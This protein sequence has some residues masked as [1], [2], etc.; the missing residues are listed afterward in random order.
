MLDEAAELELEQVNGCR[1]I[2]ALRILLDKSIRQRNR[3]RYLNRRQRG[4][5]HKV[6]ER[7]NIFEARIGSGLELERLEG[8][9]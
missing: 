1:A 9:D 5:D 6:E 7:V 2:E 3:I 8:Y 4:K